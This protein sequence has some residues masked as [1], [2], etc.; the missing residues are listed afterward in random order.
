VLLA[1]NGHR[2][3]AIVRAVSRINHKDNRQNYKSA[4]TTP[5]SRRRPG[6]S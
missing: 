1:P 5:A 3:V 6:K 4:Q 2:V